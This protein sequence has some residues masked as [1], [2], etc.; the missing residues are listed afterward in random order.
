MGRMGVG[1]IVGAASAV[2]ELIQMQLVEVVVRLDMA[3]SRV[4]LHVKVHVHVEDHGGLSIRSGSQGG[5]TG[6][7]A[8]TG[9]PCSEHRC[10]GVGGGV[11]GLE[12][13]LEVVVL[14]G[15]GFGVGVGPLRCDGWWPRAMIGRRVKLSSAGLLGAIRAA[16]DAEARHLSHSTVKLSI[17]N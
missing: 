16:M 8:G 6:R 15:V 7:G 3:V 2:L 9:D 12:S 11:L 5:A 4:R 10:V 17:S 1:V 13:G 14:V